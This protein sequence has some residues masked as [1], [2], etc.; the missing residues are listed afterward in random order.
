MYGYNAGPPST[1]VTVPCDV[2]HGY[3][4][5]WRL[6]ANVSKSVVMVF[7]TKFWVEVGRARTS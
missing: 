3:S 6:K 1:T 7:F 2:V 4:N 5:N